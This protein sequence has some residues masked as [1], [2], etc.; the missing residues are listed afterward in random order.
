MAYA[1][2]SLTNDRNTRW[3]IA[4]AVTTWGNR[5][6]WQ[7]VLSGR[8]SLVPKRQGGTPRL[9]L[10]LPDVEYLLRALR[11]QLLLRWLLGCVPSS[12]LSVLRRVT[13]HVDTSDT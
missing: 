13:A 8:K 10:A 9:R 3:A 12:V 1:G 4:P 2:L 11:A 7:K 6:A 5:T